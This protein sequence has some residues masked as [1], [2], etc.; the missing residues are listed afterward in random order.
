MLPERKI[1][2]KPKNRTAQEAERLGITTEK[3]IAM[4]D[5][6]CVPFMLVGQRRL[7]DLDITD[8]AL[9]DYARKQTE[10][11]AHRKGGN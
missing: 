6:G 1:A 4:A 2:G 11:V 8:D 3:F 7:F 10:A 5:A 9:F